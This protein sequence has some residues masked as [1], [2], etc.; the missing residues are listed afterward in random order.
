MIELPEGLS[1]ESM[2]EAHIQATYHAIC[3]YTIR[4]F[5]PYQFTKEEVNKLEEG[6]KEDDDDG[7]E[8]DDDHAS[9]KTDEE[10]LIT[11]MSEFKR[12]F[13]HK[14]MPL[15]SETLKPDR[16][17]NCDPINTKLKKNPSNALE[18]QC[19]NPSL[20]LSSVISG[21]RQRTFLKGLNP[22]A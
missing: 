16:D 6:K 15:L 19:M 4:N 2:D 11:Q 9:S 1:K 13:L 20:G 8:S 5:E 10:K 12:E 14:F 3:S 17:L 18:P 22:K 21:P 7:G